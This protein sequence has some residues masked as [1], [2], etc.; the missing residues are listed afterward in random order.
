MDKSLCLHLHLPLTCVYCDSASLTS[1]ITNNH[2][3]NYIRRES[4]NVTIDLNKTDKQFRKH[5]FHTDCYQCHI[6]V[7]GL[8]KQLPSCTVTVG[9]ALICT[10]WE[11]HQGYRVCAPLKNLSQGKRLRHRFFNGGGVWRAYG[12]IC[13]L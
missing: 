10:Q 5:H 11:P 7:I 8:Q 2:K 12:E 9:I 3:Y 6:S 4:I 1:T 13:V